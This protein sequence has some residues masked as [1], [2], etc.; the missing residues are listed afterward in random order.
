MENLKTFAT[1]LPIFSGF[2]HTIFDESEAWEEYE[3]QDES[4]FFEHYPSLAGIPFDRIKAEWWM[5]VDYSAGNRAVA[6]AC[7]YT[8]PDL[9]PD[10]VKAVEFEMVR[11][12]KEYNFTNDAVDV[13]ITVDLEA[14]KT[15]LEENEAD[16]AKFLAKRYTSRDGFMS[17]HGNTIAE[18]SEVTEKFE[19]LDGHYLGALLDFVAEDSLDNPQMDMYYAAN[20]HE[21]FSNGVTVDLEALKAACEE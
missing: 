7:A 6:E 17:F 18:W 9:L 8:L 14:L 20:T 13:K 2:Y 1:Y 15:Y 16:F 11:S 21:A 12:P 10:I 4:E 5:A 3:F 19:S